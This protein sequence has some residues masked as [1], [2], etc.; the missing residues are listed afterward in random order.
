MPIRNLIRTSKSFISNNFNFRRV[1]TSGV[2]SRDE[3][4]PTVPAAPAAIPLYEI[5]L[6][7]PNL[8]PRTLKESLNDYHDF[9][10]DIDKFQTEL[11]S[12]L[13]Y[14][15][16]ANDGKKA[17]LITT[18]VDDEGNYINEFCISPIGA[19]ADQRDL[20]HLIFIHGYGAG[21]GFFLKNFEHLPLLDNK[22][23]I[24][25]IDLPGYG[26]SKRCEFPFKY[27]EHDISDV[28]DWFHKRIRTWF[29]ARSL[30]TTPENNMIMAHSLGAYLMALYIDKF[31]NDF[32][33]IV[34]CSPAG[35]CQSSTSEEIGNIKTPWWFNKLW[36]QNVSP[37]TLVRNTYYLGSKLTSGWSYRRFKQLKQSGH[38]MQF[39][40]LHRYAYS[41]FNQ[42]GSGEY[43]LGFALKCGGDP[44][45]PLEDNLFKSPKTE[46]IP[47]S[48]CEWLWVYGEKDWMDI[49]GGKRVTDE[50]VT[51]FGKKSST[52]V[53][54]D[55][56]HH[57]YFD[58]YKF[59]NEL[60]VKE[61]KNM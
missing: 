56:G 13:P 14:Y 30:L 26:Y 61:M 29:K 58:N 16:M 6:K 27:P 24:H 5:I 11:L 17:E 1:A 7:L 46:G 8:F 23:C 47:K 21:L 34:M 33:K 25:A 31:P 53:V 10:K 3:K 12:T 36:D 52:T 59:F 60:L 32:K 19:E 49:G 42:K 2:P 9:H 35:I 38:L 51:R 50:L 39:E 28:Q 22:W 20:K 41:I 15:P 55:S 48:D 18:K 54:P 37:F 45:I 40:K 4:L 57:L 44:R 43:I